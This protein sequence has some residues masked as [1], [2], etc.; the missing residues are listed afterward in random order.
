M[1]TALRL[2]DIILD[3]AFS[4][5][6]YKNYGEWELLKYVNTRNAKRFSGVDFSKYKSPTFVS[7]LYEQKVWIIYNQWRTQYLRSWWD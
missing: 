7:Y 5:L 3:G 1:N 4:I 2:L 6:D